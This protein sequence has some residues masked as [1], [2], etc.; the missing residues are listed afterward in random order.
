[1]IVNDLK[2]LVCS[3]EVVLYAEYGKP[4]SFEFDCCGIYYD[5]NENEMYHTF[6]DREVEAI[7][8]DSDKMIIDIS[9][10][11]I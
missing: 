5:E 9:Q 7:Y 8:T 11:V 1:M 3:D 4:M 10:E 6:G 2:P